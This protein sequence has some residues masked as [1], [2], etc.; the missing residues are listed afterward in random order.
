M[1]QPRRGFTFSKVIFNREISTERNW[2]T[3]E[4][5]GSAIHIHHDFDATGITHNGWRSDRSSN[6]RHL[7]A[8]SSHLTNQSRDNLRIQFGLITLQIHNHIGI[9]KTAASHLG[10]SIGSAVM[11]PG[12][13]GPTA[14][15]MDHASNFF[16][17]GRNHDVMEFRA[18][19]GRF[20]N[21]LNQW[22]P[23]DV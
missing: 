8:R 9:G 14:E 13:F 22:L 15:R 19:A 20:P 17:V 16:T 5:H 4:V 10:N 21:V 1:Q 11:W 2:R 23:G 3:A 18:F 6:G 12:H 7:A